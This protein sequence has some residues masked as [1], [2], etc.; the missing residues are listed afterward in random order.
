MA[1]FALPL[2]SP[3]DS[4]FILLIICS[5]GPPGT[6]CVSAKHTAVIPMNVGIVSRKRLKK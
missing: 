5:T 6:N 4:P 2:V 3:P 1:D